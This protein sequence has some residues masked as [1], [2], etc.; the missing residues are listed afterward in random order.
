[1]GTDI[2]SNLLDPF[3]TPATLAAHLWTEGEKAFVPAKHLMYAS[4][5]IASAVLR[6]GSRLIISMPP[7]HGKSTIGTQATI[8]WFLEKF[9]G[10]S[11][12]LVS[13]NQDFAES[14]GGKV[15]D[16][17]NSRADLFTTRIRDDRSRVDRFETT[18]GSICHF[19][20]INSGQTGKDASL[21]VIDDYIKGIKEA[22]SQ[23]IRDDIW[24]SYVANIDSRVQNNTSIIII[25]TRWW[26]DDLI[27]RLLKNSP[28]GEWEYICMPAFA[29]A[30]DPLGRAVGDVLFPEKQSRETLLRKKRNAQVAGI[31]FDALYQQEPIDDQSAFTDGK[32]LQIGHGMKPEDYH[33][34]RAWDMAAT[35]GGG[36]YTTGTKMGRKGL[37][38]Q[39]YIFNIIRKQLSPLKV[40]ALIRNT[41]VAD[42]PECTVLLEQ[43]PG[44]QGQALVSHYERNVLPEFR[45]VGVP[46]GNKSKLLK[47]QPLIAAVE[48]GNMFMVDNRSDVEA[49]EGEA[50]WIKSFRD[51][52]DNFPPSQGGHDDQ[53][54]TAAICY[55]YLFSKKASMLAWGQADEVEE[56]TKVKVAFGI[57]SYSDIDPELDAV[58]SDDDSSGLVRGAT[59]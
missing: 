35:Q 1:M 5:R 42:G 51:E 54:D 37:T 45:V 33:C 44:S 23:T 52:F 36:D 6:Q 32:W 46:A 56:S 8:P 58:F 20:G 11:M 41:A 16:I 39:A 12:M 28:P 49:R 30:N 2:G 34:C 9:P 21:I 13:Y 53:V 31:I 48:S 22:M 10:R 38:R 40:E 14:W 43:E 4:A 7:Q 47:A 29:K 57:G 15:K 26:S 59:W 3:L 18:S 55:N 27:G 19:L 17:I 25:A 24:N 50:E